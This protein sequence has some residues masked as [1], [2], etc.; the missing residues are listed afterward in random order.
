M[1]NIMN[2]MRC[3][4][5]AL[6]VLASIHPVR[7]DGLSIG[8]RVIDITPPLDVQPG[9]VLVKD[10]MPRRYTGVRQAAEGRCVVLRAGDQSAVIISLDLLAV[11]KDFVRELQAD[12]ERETKIPAGHIRVCATHTHSMP[13][14]KPLRMHGDVPTDFMTRVRQRLVRGVRDACDDMTPATL[15]VGWARAEG[16]NFNRTSKT[17]KID[18]EFDEALVERDR[19]I[20]TM[21]HTLHFRRAQGDLLIYHFSAH[22]VVYRDDPGAGPD[23][24][25]LVNR[26]VAQKYK[27]TPCFLQGHCGDVNPGDGK[28]FLG[29]P[30]DVSA[31]IAEAIDKALSGARKV[32]VAELTIRSALFDFNLDLDRFNRDCAAFD[33][34]PEKTI[35]QPGWFKNLAFAKDWRAWAKTWDPKQTAYAAPLSVLRLGDV[36]LAFHPGELYSGYGLYARNR[37][38]FRTTLVVGYCDD[39]VGYLPDP[40]AFAADE[41][42]AVTAPKILQLPPFTPQTASAMSRHLVRMLHEAKEK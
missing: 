22:P 38:P 8:H 41:Y 2:A 35:S 20:D 29:D 16:A 9:G 34:N 33:S 18:A 3:V 15:E 4:L 21:V 39:L 24:P 10:G 40:R 1:P 14:F 11:G 27:A 26:I 42:A 36:A 23:W 13:T 12:I 25:G 28:T 32:E 17:W 6:A 19:W 30:R 31:R 5:T 37:S 7:A